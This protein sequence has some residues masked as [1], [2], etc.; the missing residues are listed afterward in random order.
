MAHYKKPK[1]IVDTS[2]RKRPAEVGSFFG[3]FGTIEPKTGCFFV[4]WTTVHV[5]HLITM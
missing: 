1:H 2:K 3:F 4:I 5:L